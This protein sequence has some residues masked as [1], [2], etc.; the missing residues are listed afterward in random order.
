[1][2]KG[3]LLS[4]DSQVVNKDR[5]YSVHRTSDGGCA[6]AHV[7][8]CCSDGDYDIWLLKTNTVG[9]YEW[10]QWMHKS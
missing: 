3:G 5:G 9:D 4:K 6:I 10:L 8:E 1:M 2:N 7:V